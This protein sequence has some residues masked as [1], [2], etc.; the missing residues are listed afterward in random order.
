MGDRSPNLRLAR[1]STRHLID[2]LR[3][4]D[5]EVV[6]RVLAFVNYVFLVPDEI[7]A[8]FFEGD[9]EA[10]ADEGA[11]FVLCVHD[12]V[13]HAP[14][15]LAGDDARLDVL[16]SGGRYEVAVPQDLLRVFDGDSFGFLGWALAA[17]AQQ[18]PQQHDSHAHPQVGDRTTAAGGIAPRQ[19]VTRR[20]GAHVTVS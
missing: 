9:A 14:V 8:F 18:H 16:R 1:L 3:V 13:D 10:V 4:G 17:K 2:A 19:F 7:A 11:E 12:H 20:V 15:P 6:R 5:V